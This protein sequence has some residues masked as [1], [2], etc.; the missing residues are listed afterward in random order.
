MNA[1]LTLLAM[2]L[3]GFQ[4]APVHLLSKKL[5]RTTRLMMQERSTL[6]G[7]VTEHNQGAL[8]RRLFASDRRNREAFERNLEHYE[9]LTDKQAAGGYPSSTC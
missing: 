4:F 5:K 2:L 7:F 9:K 1:K 3:V 8:L 6:S